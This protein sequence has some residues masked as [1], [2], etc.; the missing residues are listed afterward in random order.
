VGH[1]RS[2]GGRADVYL[3][4]KKAGEIDAWISKGTNDNDAWHR[5]DLPDGPHTVRIVVRADADARSSGTRIRLDRA[6]IYG[7]A[8]R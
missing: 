6:V 3:D 5:M 8:A 2:D 4:G 7:R 1:A